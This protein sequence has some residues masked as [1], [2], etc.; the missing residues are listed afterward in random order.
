MDHIT[1]IS[2]L[3]FHPAEFFDSVRK[4]KD[5][6]KIMITFG[7]VYLIV[8]IAAFMITIPSA[9]MGMDAVINLG[10]SLISIPFALLLVFVSTFFNAGL[11][12]LGILIVG[13][14]KGFFETYKASTY[15]MVIGAI[16]GLIPTIASGYMSGLQNNDAASLITIMLV[17]LIAI[18]IIISMIHTIYAQ[19]IGLSKGHGITKVKALIAA[20]VAPAIIF[21]IIM[22]FVLLGLVLGTAAIFS[23]A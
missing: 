18:I 4:E 15:A 23:L 13:G 14:S 20:L 7:A 5:Y 11:T 10:I 2:Q 9:L 17:F 1:K 22:L 8:Q 3:F 16:Y 19:V 12:H 21:M 6:A